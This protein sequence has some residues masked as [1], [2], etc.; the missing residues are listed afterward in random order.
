M[1]VFDKYSGEFI[2]KVTV[3]N[4]D[5]IK[6]KLISAQR[7]FTTYKN[8]SFETRMKYILT[9]VDYLRENADRL[10]ELI[11]KEAGK[12]FFYAKAEIDRCIRTSEL[13]LKYFDALERKDINVDLTETS[14]QESFTQ[15]FPIG[16]VFGISPFNFPL[17]LA[18][19]KI[20]PALAAGNV[21]IIKPSPFTP[22]SLDLL[23]N[24]INNT[25]PA[26]LV[27]IVH[28]SNED[29]EYMVK[30]PLT[31]V[32]SF[33]GSDQIGWHIKSLVP[34]KRVTLELGGNAAVFV[35]KSAD[36]NSLAQKLATATNLY[37]GQICISTQRIFVHTDIYDSFKSELIA[38]LEGINSG[39]PKDNVINGP[40][41]DP[42]HLDRLLKWIKEAQNEGGTILYGGESISEQPPILSPTLVEV[43]ST[44]VKLYQEEA[45]GPIAILRR[46]NDHLEATEMINNSKYGL[47]AG[48]FTTDSA[49]QDY[50]FNYL[51]VGGLIINGVPGFRKDEMPYGGIKDSGFG[52]EGILYAIEEMTELKLGI[53]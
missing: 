44:A 32:I 40:L 43:E 14:F 25:L 8:S 46:V 11:T 7:A 15:R 51:D 31:K 48:I 21:V 28:C 2:G 53:R 10:T 35:D 39:N 47:Q 17:N 20:I 27:N 34:K 45:F 50:M 18:L 4:R 49:V 29:A 36:L 52:R 13:G 38:A 5:S 37:S 22:L 33:T 1:D 42:I 6:E 9:I 23:I 3:D 12:P 16:I 41:I 26:G 30:H 19:H 24:E